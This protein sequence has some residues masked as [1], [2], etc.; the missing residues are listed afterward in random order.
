MSENR[1]TLQVTASPHITSPVTVNKLMWAVVFALLPAFAGSIYF[2]GLRALIITLLSVISALLF[3]A[4][5]QRLFG[6]KITLFDG[7]AVLTGI[8]LGFNLPPNVSWWMPVAGSAFAMLVAKQFFGG[9]GHNFINP[10][11]AGRAF[12][13]ASWPT[14]M[15]TSWLAPR[16]GVISGLP[17]SALNICT[18]AVTTATPLNVLK[19]GAK[20]VLPGCN[21]TN[22]YEQLQSWTTLKSLF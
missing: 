9:L 19:Q 14:Q 13:V 11:L 3:D 7:S 17:A 6:R 8:L 21:P 5:G 18:D 16:G 10:A 15:T 4:L 2:F 22:L 20:L 12:L 1:P